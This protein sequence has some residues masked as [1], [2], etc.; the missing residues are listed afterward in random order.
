MF[1]LHDAPRRRDG[2]EADGYDEALVPVDSSTAG[3]L[4]DDDLSRI[5]VNQIPVGAHL[6]AVV[7][8]CHS[9][10]ALDLENVARMD[11]RSGTVR[12][13]QVCISRNKRTRGN[14]FIVQELSL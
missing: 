9:G 11:R 2:D 8:A 7:D 13:F 4:I 3:L 10:S 6:H 1:H 12:W 5:L 14:L